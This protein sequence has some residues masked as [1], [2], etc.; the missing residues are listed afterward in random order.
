MLDDIKRHTLLTSN[1]LHHVQ[2]LSIRKF[3]EEK[4]RHHED[5]ENTYKPEQHPVN[6]ALVELFQNAPNL[7]NVA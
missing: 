4:R 3:Y 1:K 7:T 5:P 2:I 6:S